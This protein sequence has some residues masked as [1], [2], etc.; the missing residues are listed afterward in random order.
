VLRFGFIRRGAKAVRG[1]AWV[2]A[3]DGVSPS[4]PLRGVP[5]TGGGDRSVKWTA[6]RCPIASRGPTPGPDLASAS[7]A[8]VGGGLH[9]PGEEE[10]IWPH[11]GT[12]RVNRDLLL[13]IVPRSPSA[14][15][16]WRN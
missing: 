16:K 2:G 7:T 8:V 6:P 1:L 12:P 3:Q 10:I 4:L 5:T 9:R 14:S 11:T 15:R 13:V